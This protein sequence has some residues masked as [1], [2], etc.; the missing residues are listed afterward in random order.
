MP[1]NEGVVRAGL[2]IPGAAGAALP[3]LT[4]ATVQRDLNALLQSKAAKLQELKDALANAERDKEA[5]VQKVKE[6]AEKMYDD[7][8][9][10]LLQKEN[11]LTHLRGS[12]SSARTAA[13]QHGKAADQAVIYVIVAGCLLL[14]A[15]CVLCALLALT[16]AI[17][18]EIRVASARPDAP[19]VARHTA[20]GHDAADRNWRPARRAA[21]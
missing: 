16:V 17:C 10:Q 19:A 20:S 3:V 6:D 12:L 5:A 14:V 8:N 2:A 1:G 21:H 4:D 13:W 9:A 18:A 15:C 11:E 7:Y